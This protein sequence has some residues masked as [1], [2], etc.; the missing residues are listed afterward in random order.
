[1]LFRSR[2]GYESLHNLTYW[3]G[4][5]YLGLGCAAHSYMRGERFRNP[6]LDSYMRGETHIERSLIAKP[7]QLEEA[8][9]LQTRL[10]RGIDLDQIRCEFGQSVVDRLCRNAGKYPTL[11]EISPHYLRLTGE[12]LMVQNALVLELLDKLIN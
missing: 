2:P 10:T 9:M 1:M 12:G 4:G 8:I 11:A 7:E 3:T 6:D 5:E